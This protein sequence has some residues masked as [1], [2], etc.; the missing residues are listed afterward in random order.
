MSI[1]DFYIERLNLASDPRFR[2]SLRTR[3]YTTRHARMDSVV[4]E[5]IEGFDE[6]FPNEDRLAVARHFGIQHEFMDG[7]VVFPWCFRVRVHVEVCPMCRGAGVVV[8]PS[9]DA[10]GLTREDIREFDEDEYHFEEDEDGEWVES[11]PK[12]MYL[13]GGFDVRCPSCHG[14]NVIRVPDL[15]TLPEC[16]RSRILA[17]DVDEELYLSERLSE[18]RAGA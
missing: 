16:L 18:F 7:D 10:G 1:R 12:N 14:Q 11:R 3:C 9:I 17:W 15:D 8:N 13:D 2:E 5:F 4:M 6:D